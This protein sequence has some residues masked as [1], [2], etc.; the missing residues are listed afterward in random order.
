MELK[1]CTI[2]GCRPTRF[3]WKYKENNEGCQRLKQQIREQLIMLYG[4][5]VRR[6]YIGG[7]L[8]VDLWAGEILLELKG[9]PEYGELELALV[10]PYARHDR[11]W[12]KRDRHRLSVLRQYCAEAVITGTEGEAPAVNFKRRNQYMI[13]RSDCLLAVHNK[14]PK[15]RSGITQT[16]DYSRK[17]K[18]FIILIDPD[19]AAAS[20]ENQG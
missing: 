17:K 9:Q 3:K 8:G 2:A 12:D 4:Q 1:T 13:N 20:Y 7:S 11:D 19:S 5:G 6:F 18:L 16:V 10:L 14:S 15:D